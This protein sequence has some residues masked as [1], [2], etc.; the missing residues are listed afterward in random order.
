MKNN[1]IIG[2]GKGIGLEI[3]RLMNKE[4][5]IFALS[6]TISDELVSLTNNYFEF[7]TNKDDYSSLNELPDQI[8]T[9]IFCPGS[10]TLK[11]FHRITEEEFL[12][13]F[14]QNVLGAIKAI[15]FFL[16]R[17]KKS[18]SASVVL[19]SSV[20][21]QVGMTF[22]ASVSVSK[23]A[24]ESL[25]KSLASEYAPTIR[26]NCIAPSLILTPLAEKLTSTPEKIE[27]AALRHPLKRIGNVRDIAEMAV[28][29]SSD[30]STWITGQVFHVDG[31]MSNLK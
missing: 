9:L 27:S 18:S 26:V 22:H 6:R 29:L 8:D 10:I 15:Q 17:L 5:Q 31:G 12:A 24:I 2:A 16:P 11:P 13:D 4:S 21:A 1:V 19:F 23:G 30:K 7:D 3:S 20:A 14:Q 25:T 28:F